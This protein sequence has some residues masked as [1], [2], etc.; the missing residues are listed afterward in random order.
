MVKYYRNQ[1]TG[2]RDGKILIVDDPVAE[3]TITFDTTTNLC[4]DVAP[5]PDCDGTVDMGDVILL[6]NNVS[7]PE[8]PR[9]VL[10]NDWSG[11]CRCTGVKDMGDVILLLNNV[12]YP[13]VSKYALD[14]CG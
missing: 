2:L 9:Y 8:N 3:Y 14:C 7:Y 12:S 5:C 4:G 6:L 10:C 13:E 1:T 11:D